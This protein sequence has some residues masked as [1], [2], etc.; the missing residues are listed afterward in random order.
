M[1]YPGI[2]KKEENRLLMPEG[3]KE[4]NNKTYEALEIEGVII[5]IPSPI[6]KERLSQV[7]RLIDISINEHRKSLENLAK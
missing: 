5:L 4:E 7:E 2:V 6:D 1:K 3:F